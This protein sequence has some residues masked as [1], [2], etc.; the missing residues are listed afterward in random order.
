MQ[1]LLSWLPALVQSSL[2]WLPAHMESLLSWLPAHMQNSLSWLPTLMQSSLSWFPSLMQ[3]SLSWL[4][5][6]M[7]S[8]L[9][10][11]PALM[12]SSLSWLPA[13]M[14][15]SQSWLPAFMQNSLCF[16]QLVYLRVWCF[17]SVL[18]I[19]FCSLE[20]ITTGQPETLSCVDEF[21]LGQNE[22]RNRFIIASKR[23]TFVLNRSVV[24][25]TGWIYRTPSL[26]T[27]DRAVWSAQLTAA[28]KWSRVST[29][30]ASVHTESCRFWPCRILSQHRVRII[31]CPAYCALFLSRVWNLYL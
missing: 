23:T 31:I 2:A 20:F 10:W 25:V 14:Q 1:S 13:R 8:S 3:S 9:A 24:I 12:Q 16:S 18:N 4:P 5:A 29:P 7:Q 19:V 11:L 17:E 22:M 21:S 27:A 28:G 26:I 15:S 6:F 30:I